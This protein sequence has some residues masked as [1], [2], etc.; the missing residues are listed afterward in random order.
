VA[1]GRPV[2]R[3]DDYERE[4][5][6]LALFTPC[7]KEGERHHHRHHAKWCLDR[8]PSRGRGLFATRALQPGEAA[9]R[10]PS[11]GLLAVPLSS[12]EDIH[13]QAMVEAY[14]DAWA[15]DNNRGAGGATTNARLPRALRRLLTASEGDAA[16]AASLGPAVRLAALLLW[17]VA[18]AG[19]RWREYASAVLPPPPPSLLLLRLGR[20]D[21]G[22]SNDPSSSLDW[23]AEPQSMLLDAFEGELDAVAAL[24][25]AA[26]S[27]LAAKAHALRAQASAAVAAA[28]KALRLFAE[29]EEEDDEVARGWVRAVAGTATDGADRHQQQLWWWWALDMAKSRALALEVRAGAA[30]AAAGAAGPPLRLAVLAPVADLL[31]HDD[32]GGDGPLPCRCRLAA[33]EGQGSG[34][35][36]PPPPFS[37]VVAAGRSGV[38]PGQELTLDYCAAAASSGGGELCGGMDSLALACGYRF[39]PP[40]GCAADR[41]PGAAARRVW[42][43][44]AAAAADAGAKLPSLTPARRRALA[45]AAD[46]LASD[47]GAPPDLCRRAHRALASLIEACGGGRGGR[48]EEERQASSPASQE[49]QQPPSQV[50]T[51]LLRERALLEEAAVQLCDRVRWGD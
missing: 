35:R 12:A 24:E 38:A 30:A 15:M 2:E 8:G 10:L 18:G 43:A 44:A 6:A 28:T 32:G 16:V 47:A 21:G 46:E 41:L 17:A 45:R 42:L 23:R 11:S 51:A 22:T 36:N 29:D 27:D 25:G 31:N 39:V 13:Q 9:L 34:T 3:A 49:Q 40:A 7:G 1:L 48:E 19:G 26:A 14:L 50:V 5:A 33:E 20:S 4:A 37:L